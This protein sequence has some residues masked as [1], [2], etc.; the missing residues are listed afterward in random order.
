LG[1][2]K[3]GSISG[4]RQKEQKKDGKILLSPFGCDMIAAWLYCFVEYCWSAELD[5]VSPSGFHDKA[6]G[7]AALDRSNRQKRDDGN[8][9]RLW[10]FEMASFPGRGH[11]HSQPRLLAVRLGQGHL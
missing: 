7:K 4:G 2:T 3:Q 1:E 5:W 11:T 8:I 10:T 6:S 9:N